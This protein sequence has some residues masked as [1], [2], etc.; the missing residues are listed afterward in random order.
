M[1]ESQNKSMRY[2]VHVS[3][4]DITSKSPQVIAQLKI[5]D[6]LEDSEMVEG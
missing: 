2:A 5:K 1:Q 6:M 4:N 3:G